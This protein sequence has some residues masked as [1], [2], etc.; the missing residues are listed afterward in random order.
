M[1]TSPPG[2]TILELL[3]EKKISHKDFAYKMGISFKEMRKLIGGKLEITEEIAL[4]LEKV[5]SVGFR[6]WLKREENYR[7]NK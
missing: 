7:N 4:K 1:Q 5:L 3:E 2:D 6:F